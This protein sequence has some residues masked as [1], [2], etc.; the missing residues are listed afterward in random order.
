MLSESNKPLEVTT[1]R[2]QE[3]LKAPDASLIEPDNLQY[4]LLVQ[5]IHLTVESE[6]LPIEVNNSTF[7]SPCSWSVK[8]KQIKTTITELMTK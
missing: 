6:S 3:A 7:E 2:K 1:P 4:S 5:A 8:T